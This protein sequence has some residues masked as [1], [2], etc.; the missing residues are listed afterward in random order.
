MNGSIYFLTIINDYSRYYWIYFLELESEVFETF[1]IFKSLAEN[2]LEKNLK[3]LGSDN[4]G[5][6]IKI[7]FQQLCASIIFQMQHSVPY[8]PQKMCSWDEEHIFERDG[9]MPSWNKKYSIIYVGWSSEMCFM[10]IDQ[11]TPKFSGWCHSIRSING[12]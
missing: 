12:T 6:Y 5:E 4:G 1:N 3:V 9:Y 2:T 8:T 7:E 10:H 11:S